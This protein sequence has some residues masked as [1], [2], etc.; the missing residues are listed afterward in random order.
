MARNPTGASRTFL[1][2]AHAT[3]AA[4]SITPRIHF[5]DMPEGL[6]ARY[7][8]STEARMVRLR[9]AGYTLP[10]TT[11]EDGARQYVERLLATS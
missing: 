10:F 1:S 4:L 2:L 9:A 11:L 6:R 5:I 7:Q 3:F 8:Y